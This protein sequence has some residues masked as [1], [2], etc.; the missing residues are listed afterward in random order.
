MSTSLL[1]EGGSGSSGKKFEINEEI[2][3]HIFKLYPA[4]KELYEQKVVLSTGGMED[5]KFWE[6]Y[7]KSEYYRSDKGHGDQIIMGD[8]MFYK[9]DR[10]LKNKRKLELQEKQN[11]ASGKYVKRAKRAS[12]ENETKTRSERRK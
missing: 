6:Q 11:E 1:S 5:E 8:D 9:K 2:I 12:P 4:V 7:F 10:E 3:T